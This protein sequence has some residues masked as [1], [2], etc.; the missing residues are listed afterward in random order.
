LLIYFLKIRREEHWEEEGGGRRGEG[1]GEENEECNQEG[2]WNK[3]NF[4]SLHFL[5]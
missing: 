2:M 1:W 5:E 3:A 4:V